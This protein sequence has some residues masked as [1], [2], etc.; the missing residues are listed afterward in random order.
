MDDYQ[1]NVGNCGCAIKCLKTESW[2]RLK[3]YC[4][5]RKDSRNNKDGYKAELSPFLN[6]L[7]QTNL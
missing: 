7:W 5:N 6:R 2:Y 4:H 3:V 1:I